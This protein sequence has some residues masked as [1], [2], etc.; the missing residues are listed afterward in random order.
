M[1]TDLLKFINLR[2]K[3]Q[4]RLKSGLF[5]LLLFIVLIMVES[6]GSL[7]KLDPIITSEL[8]KIIPRS[9]DTAQSYFSILGSLEVTTLF[10]LVLAA[11]IF[12]NRKIVLPSLG[13]FGV[14][15]IFELIGKLFVYHPGPPKIFFRYDL[16][17]S[18]PHYL[19]TSYSFPSGHVGRTTFLIVIAVVLTIKL[20]KNKKVRTPLLVSYAILL[21]IMIVSRI[22]LGEHWASDVLGG[23]LLGGAMG[24]FAM[25]YYE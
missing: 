20:V 15:M 2:P 21:V 11:I 12:H 13:L 9:F 19:S 8:Q 18:T 22:Y 24:F 25:V 10:L 7:N 1:F 4:N 17:F 14:V 5:L 16:P 3:N 23:L 6:I